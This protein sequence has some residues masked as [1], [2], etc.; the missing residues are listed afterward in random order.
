VVGLRLTPDGGVKEQSF[1]LEVSAG[2]VTLKEEPIPENAKLT[3]AM[4]AG[5]WAAIVLGKKS[6]ESALFSRQLK[7][8]G[9]AREG[10]RLRGAFHI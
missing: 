8:D 4:P 5:T 2:R 6:L 10:L 3:I 1:V 9:E 7:V